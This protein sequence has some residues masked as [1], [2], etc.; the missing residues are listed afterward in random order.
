MAGPTEEGHYYY[1]G[2]NGESQYEP[3]AATPRRR[4]ERAVP[5][6]QRQGVGLG[7][8][9]G[10][11]LPEGWTRA[12]PNEEG[13]YYYL[14]PGG[15]CQ[16]DPPAQATTAA[17]SSWSRTASP[18]IGGLVLRTERAVQRGEALPEGWVMQGPTEE[19]HFYYLGPNGE[20]Q[21]E[22]PVFIPGAS[23]TG[24]PRQGAAAAAAAQQWP[25]QYGRRAGAAGGVSGGGTSY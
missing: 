4:A 15:E 22:A 3:P 14:G 23:A 24:M 11:G 1:L 17:A 7:G 2:P 9:L 10:L 16:W 5:Q 12:G 13:H 25:P 6:Q 19:G 8:S 20:S 21:W 18:A